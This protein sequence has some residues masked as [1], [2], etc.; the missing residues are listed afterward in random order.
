LQLVFTITHHCIKHSYRV[1]ILCIT[2]LQTV[3]T[4]IECWQ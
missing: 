3:R 4:H 1:I 2:L